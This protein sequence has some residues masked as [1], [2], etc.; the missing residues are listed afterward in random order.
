MARAI[1]L[2]KVPNPVR[3]L[4]RPPLDEPDVFEEMTLAEHLDELRSRIV[5]VCVSVGFAFIVGL[6]LAIPVLKLIRNT[7]DV[8]NFDMNEVTEG[9]TDY[10]KLRSMLRLAIAF[11]SSRTKPSRSSRRD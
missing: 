2:P 9:I 5:K 3:A 10:F 4:R 6:F 1:R 7:A 8:P 11:P